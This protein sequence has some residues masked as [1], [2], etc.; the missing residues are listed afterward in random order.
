MFAIHYRTET[1]IPCLLGRVMQRLHQD[2]AT[3]YKLYPLVSTCRRLHLS[4]IGDKT[5]ASLSPDCCWIQRDTSQPW[6]KWIVIMSPSYSLQVSRTS[7]L[8]PSTCIRRHNPD[9]SR[10]SGIHVSGRHVSW[11]KR[12]IKYCSVDF[13]T[14]TNYTLHLRHWWSVCSAATRRKSSERTW[15]LDEFTRILFL[16]AFNIWI[17][18]NLVIKWKH[19]RHL[20]NCSRQ[21]AFCHKCVGGC[22]GRFMSTHHAAIYTQ[23][24]K[25]RDERW[26][27]TRITRKPLWHSII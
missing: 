22:H 7:N 8:Y 24:S 11:C 9:T 26:R 12:G 16:I 18:T 2:T 1:T 19:D 6:H 13:N 23:Y 20:K 4:C 10:S 14:D 17:I 15:Q 3:G 5:V 25:L 21:V 27:T